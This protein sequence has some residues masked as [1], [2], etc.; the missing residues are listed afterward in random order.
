MTTPREGG[1]H[2]FNCTIIKQNKDAPE[3]VVFACDAYDL[4]DISTISRITDPT[5][6]YQRIVN[7]RRKTQIS[8]FVEISQAALPTAIVIG[9]D[10]KRK[11]C[12]VEDRKLIP[13]TTNRWTAI[14]KLR[15]QHGYKPCLIIDGQHR[16]EGIVNSSRDTFPIAVTGLLDASQ[17]IQMSNFY[18][19]NNISWKFSLPL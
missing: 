10:T 13:G 5:R 11:Y 2:Q 1:W 16:L 19:I 12:R 15:S 14:L 4:Y 9:I 6:G 7:K 17:L 3:I 8:R 18:I